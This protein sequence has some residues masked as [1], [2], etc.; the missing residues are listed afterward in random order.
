ML[1]FSSMILLLLSITLV[2][3][4]FYSTTRNTLVRLDDSDVVSQ[5][6]GGK[7]A[8]DSALFKAL[9]RGRE[10]TIPAVSRHYDR[11]TQHDCDEYPQPNHSHH[12]GGKQ[13]QHQQPQQGHQGYHPMKPMLNMTLCKDKCGETN[14]NSMESSSHSRSG[15]TNSSNCKSYI[16]PLSECY[17]SG[18]LFP[19]DPSWS[20][21]KDVLDIVICQTLIRRIYGNSTNNGTCIPSSTN[22]PN[23]DDDQ[24]QIP[25]NTCV[26]PFGQPRPWGYFQL[27][28]PTTTTTTTTA[29][30]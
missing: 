7:R 16:T 6:I 25:M 2:S 30:L 17:N 4:S 21:G 13:H 24:F 29:I 22:N 28:T 11:T 10:S 14:D 27:V 1:L 18:V 15:S 23:N 26:G 8:A 20:A 19:N 5:Y 9:I 3:F 12:L